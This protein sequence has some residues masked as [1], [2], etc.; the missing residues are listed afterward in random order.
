MI[1][2]LRRDFPFLV[3][4]KR[5]LGVT[6]KL[7]SLCFLFVLITGSIFAQPGQKSSSLAFIVLF[8]I[9]NGQALFRVGIPF[10]FKNQFSERNWTVGKELIW[11]FLEIVVSLTLGY[12]LLLFIWKVPDVPYLQDTIKNVIL[13]FVGLQLFLIPLSVYLKRE[14]VLQ[15]YLQKAKT[16]NMLLIKRGW[17]PGLVNG[18]ETMIRLKSNDGNKD[19]KLSIGDILFLKGAHNYVEVYYLVDKKLK[20]SLLRNTLKALSKDVM[21]FESFIFCHRSY[22]INVQQVANVHGNSRGY[23]V[24]LKHYDGLIPVSRQKA[25][26]FEAAI[27]NLGL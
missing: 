26:E 6:L 8:M 5:A 19:L 11:T 16:L 20:R 17:N 14:M 24:L 21:L 22:V 25:S 12:V 2:F 4:P 27:E 15:N 1:D 9:F 23:K 13:L 18:K 3:N 10:L 7:C